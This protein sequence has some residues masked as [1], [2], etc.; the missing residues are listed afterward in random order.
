MLES[1]ILDGRPVLPTVLI[2]EWLAHGALHQNPGLLFHGCDDLR[3]LHGVILDG[4]AAPSIRVDAGKAVKREGHFVAAVEFAACSR[5]D[6]RE[7]LHARAE[8]VLV[9]QLPIAPAAAPAPPCRPYRALR[10]IFIRTCCFTVPTCTVS[11]K[12][13]A[14]A[15]AASSLG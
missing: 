14:V 15:N 12:S 11:S 8:V 7:V 6:G 9:N 2:L 5:S 3:I 4:D 10:R 1:H 13:K